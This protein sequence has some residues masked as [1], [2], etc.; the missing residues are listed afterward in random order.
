MP[1]NEELQDGF[2]I[3]D[4]EV[5][6]A[7]GVLRC[8]DREETPEPL[9]FKLLMALATR[10]GN[11]ASKEDL[12][13]EVWDG[14]PVGDD[15]I[16]RCVAQLRKHLGEQGKTYVKTLTKRGYRLDEKVLFEA[17]GEARIAPDVPAMPLRNQRN[18]WMVV[19]AI[20]VALV[21]GSTTDIGSMFGK[22][23]V[24]SIA[25]LPFENL[26]GDEPDQY[27]VSGFKV[28]LVQTLHKL[29]GISVK[30]GLDTY[31]NL[32]VSE[33]AAIFDVD[34]VLFG[35]LQRIGSALKITYRIA[36][37]RDGK[38]IATGEF[39][40]Q[41]GE[42]FAL[43]EQ[44][45]YQVRSVLTGEPVQQLISHSRYPNADAY[46]RYMRGLFLLERR[47]RG[48]PENF[49]MAIDLFGQAIEID[50]A[51]GA[52]YLSL[53]SAYVLLP[54]YA[55]EPLAESIQRALDVIERGIEQDDSIEDAAAEII[56]FAHHKRR[57]WTQAE[58]A[59]VRATTADVV[60]SNAFNWYSL[61][62]SG[63]GRLDDALEQIL[64]AQK[65]DPTS[66][67]INTRL[68]MVY[69]WLGDNKNAIEYLDRAS[70]LD[71]SWPMHMWGRAVLLAREGE[72]EEAARMFDAGVTLAGG[73]VGWLG[74]FFDAL[75]DPGKTPT[76]L[77]AIDEAFSNP[78]TDSR[79]NVIVRTVLGDTDGAMNVAMALANS[80]AFS[81]VDFLFAPELR[82]LREHP[83]FMTLMKKLGVADYWEAN[84]CVWEDDRVHCPS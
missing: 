58:E 81:E 20:V 76:A 35:E 83:Q 32:E 24:D 73:A 77:A 50:P 68:G 64:I 54:D 69:T 27:R 11:V 43:Q 38:V 4:W 6:P 21:I 12:V 49:D 78:A 34:A 52:P 3:G 29:P 67:V 36:R 7:Q 79:I 74:P 41:V 15:S 39:E 61:M 46:D 22:G 18:Q 84:R 71:A 19:A 25:V 56:G 80:D 37:G 42:E 28:E 31:P 55:N 17:A 53:A 33:I 30:S 72:M 82:P 66:V 57:Q 16:T 14:Y 60:D 65:I 10:D 63:V 5:L 44:M 62:L 1:T 75:K 70:Q 26:S 48:R 40:G 9:V 51:Y 45:A 13:A 59:Y 47:G 23:Q 8:G 2:K